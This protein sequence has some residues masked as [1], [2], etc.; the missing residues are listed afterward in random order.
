MNR[1]LLRILGRCE[2]NGRWQDGEVTPKNKT[3]LGEGEGEQAGKN[4]EKKFNREKPFP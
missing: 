4:N 3:K 1:I 2:E